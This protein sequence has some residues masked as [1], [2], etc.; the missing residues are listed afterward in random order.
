MRGAGGK[1]HLPIAPTKLLLARRLLPR[2]LAGKQPLRNPGTGSRRVSRISD[3]PRRPFPSAW[4]HL[5]QGHPPNPPRRP[6]PP[7]TPPWAV[8]RHGSRD[9]DPREGTLTGTR[10]KYRSPSPT[11][12]PRVCAHLAP[13]ESQPGPYQV[14]EGIHPPTNSSLALL[15]LEVP[16]HPCPFPIQEKGV[17]GKLGR[18]GRPQGN[19]GTGTGRRWKQQ[20][21]LHQR[22]PEER[23][24]TRALADGSG[25]PPAVGPTGTEVAVSPR[26]QEWPPG[27]QPSA[28]GCW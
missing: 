23:T 2:I 3:S 20:K 13:S 18:E 6:P 17:L 12:P 8:S 22:C 7:K 28:A 1:T 19:T 24:T 16:L 26:A 15:H 25:K 9:T 14:S 11:E 4:S 21:V 5:Q 10:A 27:P